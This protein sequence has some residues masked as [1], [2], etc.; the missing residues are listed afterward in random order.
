MNHTNFTVG[1]KIKQ[2]LLSTWFT[3]LVLFWKPIV[4]TCIVNQTANLILPD[5]I[6][7]WK[8]TGFKCYE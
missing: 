3:K 6:S 7:G 4:T 5:N 2:T 8:W 1:I